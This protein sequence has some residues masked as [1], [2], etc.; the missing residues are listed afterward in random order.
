MKIHKN[1][2]F[3][4]NNFLSVGT[5]KTGDIRMGLDKISF[6][7][8]TQNIKAYN[9]FCILLESLHS[10]EM[11]VIEHLAQSKSDYKYNVIVRLKKN[12]NCY[13]FISHTHKF[14]GNNVRFEMSP[15]YGHMELFYELLYSHIGKLFPQILR[16]SIVTRIDIAMDIYD[17]NFIR[18]YIV[19]MKGARKGKM[20]TDNIDNFKQNYRIGSTTSKYS[21]IVYQKVELYDVLRQHYNKEIITVSNKGIKQLVSRI[22]IRIKERVA[23]SQL[24]DLANPLDKLELYS[25]AYLTHID[26][27]ILRKGIGKNWKKKT[28]PEIKADLMS[29]YSKAQYAS[30]R[31]DLNHYQC[32]DSVLDIDCMWKNWNNCLQ[33]L[34]NFIFAT[35]Q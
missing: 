2:I 27:K 14:S 34:G 31:A 32:R 23:F 30:L 5:V 1:A 13:V 15:Q 9:K 25:I 3:Q 26:C 21:L 28:L 7:S 8:S 24:S 10:N 4:Q 29:K 11:F 20:Y 17:P 35:H 6:T 22:E 18:N 19:S 12:L 33:V 16:K